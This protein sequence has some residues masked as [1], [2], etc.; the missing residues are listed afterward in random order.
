M[1]ILFSISDVS[2]G[3]N[4]RQCFFLNSSMLGK[5]NDFSK[6]ELS[7]LIP[8]FSFYP[9]SNVSHFFQIARSLLKINFCRSSLSKNKGFILFRACDVQNST[10]I[11]ALLECLDSRKRN[12]HLRTKSSVLRASYSTRPQNLGKAEKLILW[13]L[14]DTSSYGYLCHLT[15]WW[16]KMP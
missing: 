11:F 13:L 9:S 3:L 16:A 7:S 10:E 8:A 1:F 2:L 14:F 15:K 5:T 12:D 4:R 6:R